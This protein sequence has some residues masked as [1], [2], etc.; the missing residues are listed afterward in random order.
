MSQE[1]PAQRAAEA[2]DAIMQ[3]KT[4]VELLAF[5]DLE[6]EQVWDNARDSIDGTAEIALKTTVKIAVS[7][8]GIGR[9]KIK[10]DRLLTW[11]NN[12]GEVC[13]NYKPEES[14]PVKFELNPDL[15]NMGDR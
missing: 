3:E 8:A 11:V 13:S 5:G 12:K 1:T 10:A 6:L 7:A 9:A 4:A 15:L 14:S 2:Q